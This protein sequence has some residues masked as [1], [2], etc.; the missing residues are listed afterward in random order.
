MTLWFESDVNKEYSGFVASISTLCPPGAYSASGLLPPYV[1]GTRGYCNPGCSVSPGRFCPAGATN[2]SSLPCPPG[3]YSDSTGYYSSPSGACSACPAGRY[4][5][6]TGLTSSA[7]SGACVA[8][9]GRYC[10]EGAVSANGTGPFYV[11]S[12]R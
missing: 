2:A 8:T 6:S 10:G 11:E 9:S 5:N 4:G 1:N 7:C 3:R 12:D